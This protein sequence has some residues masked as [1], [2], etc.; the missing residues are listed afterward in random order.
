MQCAIALL[1]SKYIL[2]GFIVV[3]D[4]VDS[5]EWRLRFGKLDSDFVSP[6]QLILLNAVSIVCHDSIALKR[7]EVIGLPA[8][9]HLFPRNCDIQVTLAPRAVCPR[10]LQAAAHLAC[11]CHSSYPIREGYSLERCLRVGMLVCG[12]REAGSASGRS[13][14]SLITR[15]SCGSAML[16]S[17]CY[18]SAAD[19]HR[20]AIRLA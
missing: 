4:L 18:A 15:H 14:S 12:C 20:Y 19:T 7:I 2:F 11:G 9:E 1:Q 5:P 8:L 13:S 16:D 3:D 10:A 6:F 17:S